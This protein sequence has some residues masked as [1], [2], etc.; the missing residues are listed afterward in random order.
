MDKD[1]LMWAIGIL[2]SIIFFVVMPI[3]LV[4]LS[5]FDTRAPHSEEL[6]P[7]DIGIADLESI[8]P[9]VQAALRQYSTH[10]ISR[11]EFLEVAQR[12]RSA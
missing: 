11:A 2:F 6:G 3:I 5:R 9:E 12:A 8:S 10:R 1:E 7:E 4:K